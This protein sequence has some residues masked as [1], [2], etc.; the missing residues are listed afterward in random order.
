MS[1]LW[2]APRTSVRGCEL[3]GQGHEIADTALRAFLGSL[4]R[5]SALLLGLFPKE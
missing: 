2:A 4:V 3:S 5:L 1:G